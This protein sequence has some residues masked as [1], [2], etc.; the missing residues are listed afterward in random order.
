ML[1]EIFIKDSNQKRFALIVSSFLLMGIGYWGGII[2]WQV[3]SPEVTVDQQLMQ[4]IF[5]Q[6]FKKKQQQDQIAPLHIFGETDKIVK[7]VVKKATI[8][9]ISR[10]N[11]NLKGVFAATP[12]EASLAIISSGY[13]D[14]LLYSI[15]ETL[16]GGAVLKEVYSDRVIIDRNGSLETLV[17]PLDEAQIVDQV[18]KPASESPLTNDKVFRSTPKELRSKI[19]KDPAQLTKIMVTIPEYKN[20][21][22]IGYKL[23]MKKFKGLLEQYG[24]QE[25]DVVTSINGVA[26]NNPSNGFKILQQ[27]TNASILDLMVLR[28]GQSLPLAISLQ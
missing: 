12:A 16:P 23:R 13:K 22:I 1:L 14:E 7:P 8:A 28:N 18:I 10:L 6:K 27:L 19:L 26:L 21:K 4:S 25:T 5:S 15:G 24:L 2:F 9:P 11:L 20:G 17:L 3:M